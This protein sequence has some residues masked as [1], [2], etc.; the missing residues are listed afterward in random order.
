MQCFGAAQGLSELMALCH[1]NGKVSAVLRDS[2][3]LR[4]RNAVIRESFTQVFV[5]RPRRWWATLCWWESSIPPLL[6][7]LDDRAAGALGLHVSEDGLHELLEEGLDFDDD[8]DTIIRIGDWLNVMPEMRAA[9]VAVPTPAH[10]A[11]DRT[12]QDG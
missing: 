7:L 8:R 10:A 12:G 11:Q 1:S 2:L 5:C 6:Y 3:G 9:S 4:C